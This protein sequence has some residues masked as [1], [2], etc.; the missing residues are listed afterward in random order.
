M[1]IHEIVG[2]IIRGE[3]ALRFPLKRDHGGWV[4][5]ANGNHVL[6]IR[7]WGRLQYHED[8]EEAAAVVQD[9]IG[10]WVVETLNAEWKR[11][12]DLQRMVQV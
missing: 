12:M 2:T 10:D 3:Q 8:G 1:N 6:D 5:D 4:S 9:A 11:Q 7:G